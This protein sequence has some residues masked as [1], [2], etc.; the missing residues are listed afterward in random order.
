V[1]QKLGREKPRIVLDQSMKEA[2][3]KG[4]AEGSMFGLGE[5]KSVKYDFKKFET[6]R[7]K[8]IRGVEL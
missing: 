1:R 4:Q 8:L 7:D 5:R 2:A 3:K 6:E